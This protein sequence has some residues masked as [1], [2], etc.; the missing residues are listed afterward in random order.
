MSAERRNSGNDEPKE[1]STI[2]KQAAKGRT[3]ADADLLQWV[4][5]ED[6]EKKSGVGCQL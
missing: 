1:K 2:C 3:K 6:L 5:P 4:D